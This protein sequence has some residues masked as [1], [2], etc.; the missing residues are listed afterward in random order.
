[1]EIVS[2]ELLGP[3]RCP[4]IRLS[5]CRTDCVSVNQSYSLTNEPDR[6]V[7]KK[8][9]WTAEIGG[10]PSRRKKRSSDRVTQN[11]SRCRMMFVH[12]DFTSQHTA[13]V[14]LRAKSTFGDRRKMFLAF[15][16]ASSSSSVSFRSVAPNASAFQEEGH[17]HPLGMR[18][19]PESKWGTVRRSL[20]TNSVNKE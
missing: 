2:I 14:I 16:P 7:H 10:D 17:V 5:I 12:S 9:I 3:L 1:M 15:D 8:Y 11:V 6:L 19:P 13:F 18:T 4:S 20:F